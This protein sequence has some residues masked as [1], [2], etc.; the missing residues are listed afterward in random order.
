MGMAH[1]LGQ[2]NLPAN[3]PLA[4]PLLSR[5]A[6]L[7]TIQVP[8]PAY[9]YALLLLNEFTQTSI[10]QSSFTPFIPQGSSPLLEARKHLERAAYLH[11]APA[12]Y[13]LGHAYEYAQPPFPFDPLL[14]VQYYSLAS[15]QGEVEADMA[16]S[17]W[18]LCG[19]GDSTDG[20]NNTGFDKDE[21]L[22][23]TFAEKAA[24][25]GLPS[26]EFAMGYY[27]EVGVGRAKD[28]Q[29]AIRWY[30][31]A[32][33]HGNTDAADRLAALSQPS[34]QALSRQEHDNIT[35]DK[36][37]RKRTQAKQRSDA[38]PPPPSMPNIQN[39]HLAPGPGPVRDGKTV[40]DVI[41]KQS[42]AEIPVG[43]P[44][45]PAHQRPPGRA[46]P[47]RQG[48][49]TPPR[50]PQQQ[51]SRPQQQG[52]LQQRPGYTL[53]DTPLTTPPPGVNPTAAPPGGRPQKPG[54]I[55]SEIDTHPKP[56]KTGPATFAEMGIQGAKAEEN[57]C[58]I[59]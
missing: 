44:P 51:Q 54:R 27:A 9:V 17:K 36:L 50:Q 37:V 47:P 55:A 33:D 14:S 2:L 1:L 58:V 43:Q 20:G 56:N 12:Q 22:A 23:L 4:I 38:Q 5:A 26:A 16:L 21:V 41:R 6:T 25:K 24:K 42:M 3:P 8:Q 35:D 19:S 31:K 45:A 52:R 10:P 39:G 34:P 7:A 49:M 28:I 48:R 29:N 57:G 59:M 11:F 32:R 46:S 13:K 53:T 15:Q 18:F 40:V 30:T